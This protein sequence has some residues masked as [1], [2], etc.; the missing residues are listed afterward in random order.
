MELAEIPAAVWQTCGLRLGPLKLR[1]I[2]G[3]PRRV[4]AQIKTVIEGLC[5]KDGRTRDVCFG[6]GSWRAIA[7]DRMVGAAAIR[8]TCGMNT[9]M[10]PTSVRDNRSAHPVQRPWNELLAKSAALSPSRMA[11]VLYAAKSY[12]GWSRR[13]KPKDIA[14]FQLRHPRGDLYR[15]DAA[16]AHVTVILAD[17]KPAA[18][19][20]PKTRGRS[21]FGKRLF[22]FIP[23]STNHWPRRSG[24]QTGQGR[25]LLH[26]VSWRAHWRPDYLAP[27]CFGHDASPPLNLGGEHA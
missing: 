8:C 9:R 19:P 12:R 4:K 18:L 15:A 25:L 7:A 2:K 21:G 6:R 17:R 16:S 22:D 3:G 23:R 5:G 13:F 20:K 27:I 14:D 26:D 1:D 24:Q 10:T 11:L